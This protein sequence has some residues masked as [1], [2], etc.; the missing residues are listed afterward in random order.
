MQEEEDADEEFVITRVAARSF[1]D[2]FGGTLQDD[3]GM[4]QIAVV[5][6]VLYTGFAL[7]N[8]KDGFVG[9]RMG[10]TWSGAHPPP[11][12]CIFLSVV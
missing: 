5:C 7:S 12:E 2:E 10:L 1:S 9:R 8:C 11:P 4:L 3:L 6:V